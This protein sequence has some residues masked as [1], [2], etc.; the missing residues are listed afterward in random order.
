[1]VR[2]NATLFITALLLLILPAGCKHAKTSSSNSL[3]GDLVIFHAG[4]LAVPFK[5]IADS[6]MVL[7]PGIQVKAESAG[8]LASIRKI[9]D[10]NRPCDILAS[11]DYSLIDK[12]M[13]PAHASWNMKFAGNEM[14]IVYQKD[15][16]KSGTI[17][18]QN[19]HSILL[20]PEIKFGRSDP[21]SDP[22][23][24]RTILCLKLAEKY[25]HQPGLADRFSTKDERYIRP[26]EVDLLALLESGTIDYIFIYKS[27]AIQH[28]LAYLELPDSI[29][30]G[31]PSLQDH[32]SGVNVRI[33]GN[34]PGE[35]ITQQG[36]PI[37]YGLT[38]PENCEN[39]EAAKAFVELMMKNGRKIMEKSG[40]NNVGPFLSG[41]PEKLPE[42]L[43][44]LLK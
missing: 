27:V 21:D 6:F 3:S 22:C 38:I 19:W 12:L 7:N 16:L 44:P 41:N 30:L 15:P 18:Q 13:I 23:G 14:V 26:K 5:E 42:N 35:Y 24:Y 8:S 43:K 17:N 29:N 31:N 32:Y 39:H 4:S 37:V 33:A 40:Q 1:M 20:D 25:Y 9:T 34:K 2:V 10:L 28:K 11:A 36:E